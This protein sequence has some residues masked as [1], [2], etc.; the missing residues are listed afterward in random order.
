MVP[1]HAQSDGVVEDRTVSR[2]VA[3]SCDRFLGVYAEVTVTGS[4]TVGDDVV[5]LGRTP[6]PLAARVA[7]PVLRQVARPA[8]RLGARLLPRGGG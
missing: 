1:G 4:L 3:R 6:V 8:L 2:F 5:S 7:G